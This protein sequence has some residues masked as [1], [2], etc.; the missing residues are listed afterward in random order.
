MRQD[1]ENSMESRKIA[2]ISRENRFSGR[3][4]EWVFGLFCLSMIILSMTMGVDFFVEVFTD[5]AY[6]YFKIAYNIT[7]GSGVTFDGQNPT[8]GFHPLWMLL[9]LPIF[10]LIDTDLIW[11]LRAVLVLQTLLFCV[12]ALH[13]YRLLARRYGTYAAWCGVELLFQRPGNRVNADASFCLA[14]ECRKEILVEPW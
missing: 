4:W 11:P 2:E 7:H 10:G 12:A 6:Y 1:S 9:L 14:L 8:N 5:D 13:A 3:S